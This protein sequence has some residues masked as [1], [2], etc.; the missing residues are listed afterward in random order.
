V[1]IQSRIGRSNEYL[2]LNNNK[3]KK[4]IPLRSKF[5]PTKVIYTTQTK[6][7]IYKYTYIMR[8]NRP[9]T[10]NH[11]AEFRQRLG[12]WFAERYSTYGTRKART[13]GTL[14]KSRFYKKKKQTKI[15]NYY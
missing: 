10:N 3:K 15:C 12:N 7:N 1:I 2:S 6:Q 5:H 4:E 9:N 14:K 11:D 13:G 8:E